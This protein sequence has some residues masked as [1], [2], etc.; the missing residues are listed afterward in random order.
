MLTPTWG[1]R[2]KSWSQIKYLTNTYHFLLLDMIRKVLCYDVSVGQQDVAD[3][4]RERKSQWKFT[5]SY[6][7]GT[8][9]AREGK[10]HLGES[11]HV[12]SN[13]LRV[14]TLQLADDFKALIELREHIHHGAGEQSVLWSY[15]ELENERKERDQREKCGIRSVPDSS[16]TQ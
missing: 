12:I 13:N 1:H 16:G 3:G 2:K 14:G 11:L 8:R 9:W 4:L 5:H 6:L 7:W 15:L 10:S